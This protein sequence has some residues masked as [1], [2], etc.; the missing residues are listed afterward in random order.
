[1]RKPFGWTRP[2]QTSLRALCACCALWVTPAVALPAAD[3]TTPTT[4]I[5]PTAPASSASLAN[6]RTAQVG[7][8]W[9]D[10]RVLMLI[11]MGCLIGMIA[12]WASGGPRETRFRLLNKPK[13]TQVSVLVPPGPAPRLIPGDSPNATRARSTRAPVLRQTPAAGP[14][15]SRV[16]DYIAPFAD[17]AARSEAARIDY[18]L[19]SSEDVEQSLDPPNELEDSFRRTG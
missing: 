8:V 18:L 4:A 11:A 1:M 13:K 16:I 2:T 7:G 14:A 17:P 9:F 3:H 15:R 6:N 5:S 10:R 19:S 12:G